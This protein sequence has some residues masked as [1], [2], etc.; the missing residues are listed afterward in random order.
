VVMA[1]LSV[2]VPVLAVVLLSLLL[3]FGI[4][5]LKRTGLIRRRRTA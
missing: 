4:R 5:L 1:V 3:I 2:L